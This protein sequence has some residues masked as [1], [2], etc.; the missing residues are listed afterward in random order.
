MKIMVYGEKKKKKNNLSN[1]EGTTEVDVTATQTAEQ[2][3]KR[4]QSSYVETTLQVF[5]FL[6][7]VFPA[8]KK[9]S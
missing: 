3:K 1:G 6:K 2:K 8:Q 7:T 5:F 4:I 9:S